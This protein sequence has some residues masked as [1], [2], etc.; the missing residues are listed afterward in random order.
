[1]LFFR[2]IGTGGVFSI[3]LLSKIF[4]NRLALGLL[5][6]IGGLGLHEHCDELID[7]PDEEQ[8]KR[9]D[10]AYHES[11]AALKEVERGTEVR[12]LET[13]EL[14][15]VGVNTGIDL[16]CNDL[17]G[18]NYNA[19]F[20]AHGVALGYEELDRAVGIVLDIGDPM[21][22]VARHASSVAVR[23]DGSVGDDVALLKSCYVLDLFRNYKVAGSKRRRH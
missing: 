8:R 19:V 14:I 15:A 9:N 23:D 10:D 22:V 13:L 2:L 4:L 7:L 1:M 5:A 20:G 3:V 17:I 16:L 21:R 6:E 12:D 18:K 11:G